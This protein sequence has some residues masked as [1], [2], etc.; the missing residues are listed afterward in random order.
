MTDPFVARLAREISPD[1][2]LHASTQT[3]TTSAAWRGDLAAFREN[4]PPVGT[5]QTVTVTGVDDFL[6][7]GNVAYTITT[8]AATSTVA[9]PSS[10]TRV[11]RSAAGSSPS[12]RAWTT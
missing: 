8:A 11:A 6:D 2:V 1:V 5:A 7:D 10:A 12:S 9:S 3:T 4:A